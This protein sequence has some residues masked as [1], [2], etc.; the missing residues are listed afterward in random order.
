MQ[1]DGD[2]VEFDLA[3]GGGAD[4][5]ARVGLDGQ[6]FG[7]RF[8]DE[9]RRLAVELG[10]DDEQF[11]VGGGRH[12]RF[13]AGQPVPAGGADRGRLQR[14]RVEQRMR[15]GD[16]DAG[17][18]D[19]LAGEL[20]QV[21]GLLV[22]AAPV[23]QGRG[24]TTGRQDRQGQAHIA[25]GQRLGDQRG[26]DGGTVGSDPVE[27]FGDVDGGDAE[28]GCL[29]DQVNGVGRGIVGVVRGGAQDLGG[30]LL[31]G[32]DDELLILVG[33]EVEV[34]G[35]TGLEPGGRLAESL[36]ALDLARRGAS[37]G[38]R[39]LD[40]VAQ[41][42]VERIAQAVAVQEFLADDGGDQRQSNIGRCPL[43]LLQPDGTL[44]SGALGAGFDLGHVQ[45]RLVG[46]VCHDRILLPSKIG[47]SCY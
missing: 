17:L 10:A 3:Q 26:G 1:R 45:P 9:Q 2:V 28:F 14:G 39:R 41:A 36:D 11:G 33:R 44:G 16:G 35:S 20:G 4:A 25:V 32:F 27:I 31:D 18:R 42:L 22:G 43:V 6:P 23:G 29:G 40:A 5:H 12:Q 46:A 24:D 47:K 21:G 30:E 37:G 19:V 7:L 38:E 34:V 15:F 13:D 8:D